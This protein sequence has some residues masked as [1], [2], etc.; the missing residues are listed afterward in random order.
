MS[1]RNGGYPVERSRHAPGKVH[2]VTL[3]GT[4]SKIGVYVG[5][6]NVPE[7]KTSGV[8]CERCK[9]ILKK[10]GRPVAAGKAQLSRCK[11]GHRYN[12]HGLVTNLGGSCMAGCPCVGFTRR[13][14][15]ETIT[16][17]EL[18]RLQ[19]VSKTEGFYQLGI[20]RYLDVGIGMHEHG[21]ADGS[22]IL[23][24]EDDGSV[25]ADK[26]RAPLPGI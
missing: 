18:K 13:S 6:P 3:C 12:Q 26:R 2:G 22:E 24:T 9:R 4:R 1:R 16:Y 21:P 25:P 23:V 17:S 15:Q 14:N 20:F 19:L 10:Q 8:N 7:Y 11:C 5:D